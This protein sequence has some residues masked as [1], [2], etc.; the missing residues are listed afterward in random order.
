MYYVFNNAK[1]HCLMFN[2][3]TFATDFLQRRE[4]LPAYVKRAWFLNVYRLKS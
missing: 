3:L 4:L 1:Q 2:S